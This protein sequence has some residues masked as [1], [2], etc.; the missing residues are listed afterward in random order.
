M[1][2][3]KAGISTCKTRSVRPDNE[4]EAKRAPGS[5]ILLKD[6]ALHT[7]KRTGSL[8]NVTEQKK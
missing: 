6:A 4:S 1:L 3:E 8:I 2:K 7:L 5:L